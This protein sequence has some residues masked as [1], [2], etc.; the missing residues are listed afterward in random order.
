ML[1]RLTI[2]DFDRRLNGSFSLELD[3]SAKMELELV[4]VRS[5]TDEPMEADHRNPFS[6]E[7]RGPAQPVLSQRI[8]AL[9][10]SEM[11]RLEIFL[12]PIGPDRSGMLYEAVF[13]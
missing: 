5:L 10:H 1:E 11:G 4:K 12:V 9:R 6:V 13:T 3:E 7:F 8:Y 2:E